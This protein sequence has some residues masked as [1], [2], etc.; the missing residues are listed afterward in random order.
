MLTEKNQTSKAKRSA[1]YK[2]RRQALFQNQLLLLLEEKMGAE[3][4]IYEE[5][6]FNEKENGKLMLKAIEL[7]EEEA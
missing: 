5:H 6:D 1:V 4:S 3:G 7:L 2:E